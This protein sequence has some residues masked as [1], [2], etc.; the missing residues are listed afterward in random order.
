[1][2]NPANDTS[3][4]LLDEARARL[5]RVASV[6]D[7]KKIRD[8]A[9]AME[10]YARQQKGALDAANKAS[11]IKVRAER[12]IG[13]LLKA[14]PRVEPK[15]AGKRG[16]RPS[17]TTPHDGESFRSEVV[18]PKTPL[19]EVIER[20]EITPRMAEDCQKL[21]EI[22]APLFEAAVVTMQTDPE[23]KHRGVSTAGM[24]RVHRESD[25]SIE[26]IKRAVNKEVAELP[27]TRY[28]AVVQ[29]FGKAIVEL[30]ELSRES[31]FVRFVRGR[32]GD[33]T[34]LREWFK[35]ARRIEKEILP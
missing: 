7:A 6:D 33:Q 2:G 14:V 5:A 15:D 1:M 17:K 32:K 18:K 20:A 12:R 23:I 30:E 9:A 10:H 21:A 11:E 34:A 28:S 22:P 27:E 8:Q 31:S 29:K 3:L 35:A 25:G 19:R 16:G 4:V 24:L 13:E 26:S